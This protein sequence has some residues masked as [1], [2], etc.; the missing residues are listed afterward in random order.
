MKKILYS[1]ITLLLLIVIALY[2]VSKTSD[3]YVL[4]VKEL[5]KS[6]SNLK[7]IGIARH[8][9]LVGSNHKLKPNDISCGKFIFLVNG[10]T[11]FG[12]VEILVRKKNFH[13]KWEVYDTL[14]G[15][16]SFSEKSCKNKI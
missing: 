15:L 14:E 5:Y 13:G 3:S 16:T 9:L 7:S 4:A 8:S 2:F 11:G 10:A 12:I 6:E 1:V